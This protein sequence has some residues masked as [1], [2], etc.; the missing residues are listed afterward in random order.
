MEKRA[1]ELKIEAGE[2][3]RE[4]ISI[5]EQVKATDPKTA[6]KALELIGKHL[7]MWDGSGNPKTEEI[8]QPQTIVFEI[9]KSY[10]I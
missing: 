2:I 6:L 7:G 4:I 1:E 10:D 8:K 3:L 5:K 9:V